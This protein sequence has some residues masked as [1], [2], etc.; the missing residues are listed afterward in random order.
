MYRDTLKM[1]RII[2]ELSYEDTVANVARMASKLA[3]WVSK[4]ADLAM[5]P[6]VEAA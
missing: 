1:D 3:N 5:A 2:R 4:S 6:A